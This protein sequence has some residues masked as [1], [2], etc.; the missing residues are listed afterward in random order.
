MPGV[1]GGLLGDSG[2]TGGVDT[3]RGR[4][5][6]AQVARCNTSLTVDGPWTGVPVWSHLVA[7]VT[8]EGSTQWAVA[9]PHPHPSGE[10]SEPVD[11]D[12]LGTRDGSRLV[13]NDSR[14]TVNTPVP[15]LRN[16]GRSVH[17]SRVRTLDYWNRQMKRKTRR[18]RSGHF[19]HTSGFET[20]TTLPLY[21]IAPLPDRPRTVYHPRVTY[22]K[23]RGKA[24]DTDGSSTC[25]RMGSSS[26]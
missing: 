4:R 17:P 1:E 11:R 13:P 19:T 21:I 20:A 7:P 14:S 2:T 25:A 22:L 15:H 5:G 18:Q 8:G 3:V 24:Q 23:G 10:R 16:P 12:G 9:S 26:P 6:R